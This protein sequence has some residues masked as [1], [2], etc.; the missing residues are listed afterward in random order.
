MLRS[1]GLVN[2]GRRFSAPFSI[3]PTPT[4]GA[5]RLEPPLASMV[6]GCV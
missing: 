2:D 5:M 4:T 3:E 6:P 1:V